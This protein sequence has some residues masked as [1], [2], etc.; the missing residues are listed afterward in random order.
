MLKEIIYKLDCYVNNWH[1]K[2]KNPFKP[3]ILKYRLAT[4]LFVN[5]T[6]TN[7][8]KKTLLNQSKKEKKNNIWKHLQL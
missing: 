1:V 5:Y 4:H 6:F 8:Q 7:V 2:H 3:E